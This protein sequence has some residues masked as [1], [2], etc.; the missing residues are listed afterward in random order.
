MIMFWVLAISLVIVAL[1]FLV[2][3]FFTETKK[4][5]VERSALNVKI[6]KERILELEVELEQATISKKEYE[7]TREE[8]EQALLNDLEQETHTS[9][10]LNKGD[11]NKF[12]R[13]IFIVCVPVFAISLY[14]Y[15]GQP[16]LIEGGKKQ[17]T[18]SAGHGSNGKTNIGTIEQMIEK[19]AARLKEDPNNAEGWFMLG[20]SYMSINRYK[21]AVDALEKTNQLVPNNPTVM[22]RYADALTMLKG[23]QI[24]GKPFDLIK[25][26]VAIKPDDQTGLW[27][28][29]MGYE[30]QGEYEKAISY[31][32]L[33]L[34]L[35]KDESS[36]VEVNNLI[37]Q[38]KRKAGID[39]TASVQSKS[40]TP[41]INKKSGSRLSVSVT[42]DKSVLKNTSANDVVFIFAKALTGPPMPLAIVRKQVKD[43]PLQVVLDDTMAMTPTMKLSNFNKVQVLARISKSGTAK[44]QSGDLESDTQV[45]SVN[46]KDKIN[47]SINKLIP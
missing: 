34:P 5:E 25:K 22:L 45:V 17:T 33:L 21:E 15:L 39:I 2:R 41:N 36:I 19:L 38:A 43:L 12:T 27:L 20:R 23:G 35:L 46:K 30:E 31:W 7:Q 26:A 29:G 8:L 4:D 44:S 14:L 1:F 42:I 24:S 9:T 13:I 28:L 40:Q 37:R 6:T 32:N 18:T 10:E 11:Y 16:E 47:L 3:P